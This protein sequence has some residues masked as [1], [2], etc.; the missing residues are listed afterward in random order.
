MKIAG[1]LA[2]GVIKAVIALAW[3]LPAPALAA[4]GYVYDAT[5]TV[6]VT[7]GKNASHPVV[8]NDAI[9]SDAVVNTGDKSYAV[10]KFED[11]Q[12]ATMQANTTIYVREYRYDT[13]LINKNSV[14]FSRFSGGMR[15]ITGLIGQRNHKAFRL[16]TP[17][18][19]IGIRGTEFMVAMDKGA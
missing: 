6:S 17:N 3:L 16:S 18:A 14:F 5:G 19:T 7:I 4:G 11:G 15:F 2:R 1:F 10:L 12:V 13:K 9:T 8:K